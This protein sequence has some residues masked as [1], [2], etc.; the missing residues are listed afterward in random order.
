MFLSIIIAVLILGFLILV[1]EFGHFIAAKKTGIKVEEFGLGYPPKIL[2]F[3]KGETIYS[4]NLIPFGGFVRLYGEEEKKGE[5][6]KEP[7]SFSAKPAIVRALTVS[8]GVIMNFLLAV[9]IFYFLLPAAGFVN[10]QYLIFNYHFPFGQQRNFP[11]ISFVAENSP[12]EKAGLTSKDVILGGDGIKFERAGEFIK[13][14]NSHKGKEI[15]LKIKNLDSG[16]VKEI[17]ISPRL[18]PPQGEGPLGIGLGNMAEIEYKTGLERAAAGFLHS[19]NLI[20]YSGAAFAYLIKTSFVRASIKPLSSTVVGPVGILAITRLT[21]KAG[22][23]AVFNLV[24]LIS[25][26]L[27]FVNII[28]FPALDGGRLFFIAFESLFKKRIPQIIERNINLAGFVFLL[29]LLV[30]ITI[31]DIA[32]FGSVFF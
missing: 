4:L 5:C 6:F 16:A 26:A 27:V 29:L 31:K 18:N 17:Q 21:L 19:L 20:H 15:F 2:S 14:V 13:F 7:F 1:H 22:T 25:L 12:A 30:L 28:P 24:A 11:L 3:K 10:K 9:V 32:Q 8:A 23:A